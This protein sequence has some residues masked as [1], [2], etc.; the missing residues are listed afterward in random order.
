MTATL[1]ARLAQLTLELVSIESVT[2]D[3]EA[4][5]DH[6]EGWLRERYAG[7]VIRSGN[8][9][10]AMPP[11]DDRPTLALFG[12]LDTVPGR[13]DGPP[14][15]SADQVHGTGSSD[16]KGALAVMMALAEDTDPLALPVRVIHVFYDREEGPYLESGLIPLHEDIGE[17]FRAIDLAICMEPTDGTIQMGCTGT[18][19]ATIRFEGRRAHSARP[20]QGDNA[21]HQAGAFLSEMHAREPID[22]RRGDL[23]FRE[24]MTVTTTKSPA[25]RNVVPDWFELNLNYR[26]APGKSLDQAQQD[27]RDAVGDRATVEFTDLCPSGET[28]LDNPHVQRLLRVTGAAVEPKQ[29]WTD[30]ARLQ[31]WGFDAIHMGPGEGAQAHQ[32]N[33]TA[34]IAPLASTY[35]DLL[36][37]LSTAD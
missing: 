9:V 26:F 27:V 13:E 30:V 20:W 31:Q 6:V 21:I 15:I 22:I 37:Y 2:G 19:H 4:I 36:R 24:V 7:E 29:A 32:R 5:A 33:E 25:A 11:E 16:M 3:E 35:G 18:L 8:S 28:C 17:R 12:H 10:V 34:P 14:R 1:D 23:I